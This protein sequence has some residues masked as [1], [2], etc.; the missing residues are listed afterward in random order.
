MLARIW[1]GELKTWQRCTALLL[2]V[3]LALVLAR[4]DHHT[5]LAYRLNL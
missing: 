3:V 4:I 5:R 1:S 2:I